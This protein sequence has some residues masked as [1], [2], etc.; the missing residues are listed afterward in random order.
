MVNY[1]KHL[2]ITARLGG[3]CNDLKVFPSKTLC[4][5]GDGGKFSQYDIQRDR[6]LW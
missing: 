3:I 2:I 5:A 4:E 1:K 6:V